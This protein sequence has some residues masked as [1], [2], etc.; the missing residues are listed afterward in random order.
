MTPQ[1]R[2]LKVIELLE[3]MRPHTIGLGVPITSLKGV[4]GDLNINDM[5]IEKYEQL[6]KECLVWEKALVSLTAGGSEFCGDPA[7]CVDFVRRVKAD[8]HN[9]IIQQAKRI[10]DLEKQL[11]SYHEQNP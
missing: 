3:L 10:K 7:N 1:D 6:Q 11:K 8:Q 9:F 4:V 2:L 5:M